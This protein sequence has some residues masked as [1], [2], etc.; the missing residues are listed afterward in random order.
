[1]NEYGLHA[2]A[3]RDSLAPPRP[4]DDDFRIFWSEME[5]ILDVILDK[6]ESCYL[7]FHRVLDGLLVK[8]SPTDADIKV[9]RDHVPNN[10]VTYHY[11]FQKL[12]SPAW[13]EPL[14]AAGFFEDPPKPIQDEKG[15]G[16]APWPQSQ[17]LARMA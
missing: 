10:L 15:V 17:Y 9:L 4:L 6:L 7:E 16:F 2:R 12:S 1:K 3:H 5:A 8:P 14:A 13:L 11:F